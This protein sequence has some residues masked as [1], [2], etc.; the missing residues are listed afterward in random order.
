MML[1]CY[2]QLP[3]PRSTLAGFWMH[4]TYV[5]KHVLTLVRARWAEAVTGDPSGHN[6]QDMCQLT[7]PAVQPWYQDHIANRAVTSH[8][9]SA[10][11]R[12]LQARLDA[13]QGRQLVVLNEV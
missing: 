10:A 12:L 3:V 6:T 5:L 9:V 2:A 4:W 1:A 11:S 8:A 7:M 13:E